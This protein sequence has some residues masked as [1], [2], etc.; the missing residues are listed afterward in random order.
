MTLVYKFGSVE[1]WQIQENYGFDFYVYGV[2]SSPYV[3]P[4]F[5]MA[6]AIAAKI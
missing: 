1:I 3:V 2:S 5:D 4:S 6:K